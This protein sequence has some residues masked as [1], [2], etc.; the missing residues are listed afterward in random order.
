MLSGIRHFFKQ[1]YADITIFEHPAL[2]GAKSAVAMSQRVQRYGKDKSKL[3][4][5]MDMVLEC[6]VH[7]ASK[8]SIKSTM[9][10]VAVVL[11]FFCL[12]RSSEYLFL[13]KME[14]LGRG[15]ALRTDDVEWLCNG[16]DGMTM[17]V[18][19]Y[20][21]HTI[22]LKSVIAVKITLHSAKNDKHQV[23]HVLFYERLGKD[24]VMLDFVG[25]LFEWA[26]KA[27]SRSGDLFISQRYAEQPPKYV[28]Y[29]AMRDTIRNTAGRFGFDPSQFGTH[30]A[31]IGGAST[32][33]NGGAPDSMIQGIGRWNC[34]QTPNYYS[35][36]SRE[37]YRRM[38]LV[39]ANKD[40]FNVDDVRLLVQSQAKGRKGGPNLAPESSV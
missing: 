10:G 24:E 6:L 37:E 15:H 16:T 18:P 27:R 36:H 8:K 30:S 39:L 26:C 5:T 19:S 13:P 28:T 34:A 40:A 33:R 1:G 7:L 23:G 12:L 29:G 35:K 25:F 3:P 22:D 2:V 21:A 31:R 9:I 14:K 20:L 38:Q 32:L 11:A 17:L 4:L